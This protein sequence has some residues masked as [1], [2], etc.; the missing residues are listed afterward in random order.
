MLIESPFYTPHQVVFAKENHQML[1]LLYTNVSY[2]ISDKAKPN[3]Q[4]LAPDVI[5]TETF[6]YGIQS[7]VVSCKNT[8]LPLSLLSVAS[9]LLLSLN[10]RASL[11][12]LEE[13]E[14]R[15]LAIYYRK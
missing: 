14:T 8:H 15:L 9:I 4:L 2:V 11:L 6:R 3:T 12:C 5:V 1:N 13:F 10:Q 7:L